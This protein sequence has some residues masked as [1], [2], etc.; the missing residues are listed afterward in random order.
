VSAELV[1]EVAARSLNAQQLVERLEQDMSN[2]E[3][4]DFIESNAEKAS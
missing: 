3:I 1:T 4:L 2:P